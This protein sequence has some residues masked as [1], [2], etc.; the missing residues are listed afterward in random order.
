M[1]HLP[2]LFKFFLSAGKKSLAI[3]MHSPFLP[4]IGRPH[5]PSGVT[6][7]AM[8]KHIRAVR[9]LLKSHGYLHA[10]RYLRS[11]GLTFPTARTMVRE[12]AADAPWYRR[13]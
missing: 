3:C 9:A 1:L 13:A 7:H 2:P 6:S 12:I 5:E 11:L 10:V 8:N 4:S